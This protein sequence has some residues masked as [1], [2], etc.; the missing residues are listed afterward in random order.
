M[1]PLTVIII[2]PFSSQEGKI[3]LPPLYLQGS[4]LCLQT[5]RS[6]P[7]GGGRGRWCCLLSISRILPLSPICLDFSFYV[8]RLPLSVSRLLFLSPLLL[9]LYTLG[10]SLSLPKMLPPCLQAALLLS[11]GC[12]L[13]LFRF[14]YSLHLSLAT[15]TAQSPLEPVH[16]YFSFQN[17]MI[18][19][20]FVWCPL[21]KDFSAIS[22][23]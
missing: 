9:A 4:P 20:G 6:F 23:I 15:S 14:P 8:F 17:G 10:C 19:Q 5:A 11:L 7:L 16:A 21:E 22:Q 1:L 18:V 2:V 3:V 12:S 13:A